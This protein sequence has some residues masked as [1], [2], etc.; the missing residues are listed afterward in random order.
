METLWLIPIHVRPVISFNA[1]L[2]G[3]VR[4]P[5]NGMDRLNLTDVGDIFFNLFRDSKAR[6]RLKNVEPP[7]PWEMVFWMNGEAKVSLRGIKVGP[8]TY[9]SIFKMVHNREDEVISIISA[10]LRSLGRDPLDSPYWNDENWQLFQKM[11]RLTRD[12]IDSDNNS[13]HAPDIFRTPCPARSR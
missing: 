9:R 8:S 1:L 2:D 7:F 13:F 4:E 3:K 10:G 5:S 12:A 11:F 6:V